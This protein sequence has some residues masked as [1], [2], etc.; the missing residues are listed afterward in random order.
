[1]DVDEREMGK[2]DLSVVTEEVRTSIASSAAAELGTFGTATLG[3]F[4]VGESSFS[5]ASKPNVSG[6]S[7]S[8]GV[9]G[10]VGLI[11]AHPL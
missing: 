6:W 3:T 5:E 4:A 8:T 10:W 2:M 9:V 11:T 1:M 7:H